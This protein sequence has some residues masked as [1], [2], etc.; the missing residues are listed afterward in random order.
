M[1]ASNINI[2]GG[3]AITQDIT[4]IT[5]GANVTLNG[6]A[7]Q[8]SE[9]Q[10]GIIELYD[11]QTE[12]YTELGNTHSSFS[13]IVLIPGTYDITYS[14]ET[15]D[16]VPQN[17][18]GTILSQQLID[19]DGIIEVNVEGIQVTPA[20]TLNTTTF[21]QSTYQSADLM[22]VGDQSSND[23]LLANTAAL[24]E[25]VMVLPGTYDLVYRHKNGQ[26]VPQNTNFTLLAAQNLQANSQLIVNVQSVHIRLAASLNQQAFPQSQY[27]TADIYASSGTGDEILVLETHASGNAIMLIPGDYQFFYQHI[28]GDQIP[29]NSWALVGTESIAPLPSQ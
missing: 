11:N 10:D 4:A 22:L 25:S 5:I 21:P 2:T 3:G 23:I 9:Y 27:Q 7:F 1:I 24:N 28:N 19:S 14:H 17:S 20:V 15:G 29:L 26:E 16:A 13:D 6:G 8:V 12:S 18:H